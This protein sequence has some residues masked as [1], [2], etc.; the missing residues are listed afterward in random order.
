VGKRG[1]ERGQCGDP[2]QCFRLAA[3]EVRVGELDEAQNAHDFDIA[4]R[5]LE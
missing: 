2:A 1:L 3:I 4:N 5:I